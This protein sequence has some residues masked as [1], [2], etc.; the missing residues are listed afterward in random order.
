MLV[1]IVNIALATQREGMAY[2]KLS[3]W[4]DTPMTF[5]TDSLVGPRVETQDPSI[6][7]ANGGDRTMWIKWV[8]SPVYFSRPFYPEKYTGKQSIDGGRIRIDPGQFIF[9]PSKN[10]RREGVRVVPLIGCD[11]NGGEC[12]VGTEGVTPYFEFSF[13]R[14]TDTDTVLISAETGFTLPFTLSY[15]SR[16]TAGGGRAKARDVTTM[17][18]SLPPE[19]CPDEFKVQ[20]DDNN[21]IGCDSSQRHL[22]SQNCLVTQSP[23]PHLVG[24]PMFDRGTAQSILLQGSRKNRF[25]LTFYDTGFEWI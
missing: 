17:T 8:A 13:N 10:R 12:Q 14:D 1:W 5:P 21:F 16:D 20:N 3:K 19:E 25:K 11:D 18:C 2:S 23:T 22:L 4:L 24:S 7:I 9:F 15:C 6:Q